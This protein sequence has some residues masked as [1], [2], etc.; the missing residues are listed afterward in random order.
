[1]AFWSGW[2]SKGG[3]TRKEGYQNVGP[4]SG[5]ASYNSVTFDSAMTL[6]AFWASTRLLTETVAA[7]PLRCYE[8]NPQTNVKQPKTDYD[9]LSDPNGLSLRDYQIKVKVSVN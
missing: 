9:L 1:M 2:F 8:I 4:S 7:M 6:S 3:P 5:R